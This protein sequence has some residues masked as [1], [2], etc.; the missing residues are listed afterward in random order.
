MGS[1]RRPASQS[2]SLHVDSSTLTHPR[3]PSSSGSLLPDECAA[4]IHTGALVTRLSA[5]SRGPTAMP[6]TCALHTY[7]RTPDIAHV[8]MQG[9]QAVVYLDSLQGR[10]RKVDTDE[11]VTFPA[12]VL[13]RPIRAACTRV[14]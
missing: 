10:V 13:S 9:L 7:F 8:H 4:N 5:V 12:E 11:A 1:F 6:F 2:L 14:A 3:S